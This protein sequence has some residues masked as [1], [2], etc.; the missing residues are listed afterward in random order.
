MGSQTL[1]EWTQDILGPGDRG[2]LGEPS[3]RAVCKSGAPHPSGD[4]NS[5]ASVLTL[6]DDVLGP[7]RPAQPVPPSL[8]LGTSLKKTMGEGLPRPTAV[9]GC[10][11]AQA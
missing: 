8:S 6:R 5:S 4:G 9:R 10:A 3:T 11:A 1:S 2:T 7:G